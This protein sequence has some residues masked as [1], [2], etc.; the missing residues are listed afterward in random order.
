VRDLAKEKRKRK[1]GGHWD[2][3]TVEG[4]SR[5]SKG[6]W[7][8]KGTNHLVGQKK[9][10]ASTKTKKKKKK[11]TNDH[12]TGGGLSPWERAGTDKKSKTTSLKNTAIKRGPQKPKKLCH[13]REL[14]S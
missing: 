2:T 11:K 8:E 1:N 7:V 13:R 10:E 9:K 4:G 3:D 6:P 14:P 5:E 12:Q